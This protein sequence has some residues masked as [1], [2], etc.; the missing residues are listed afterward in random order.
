M[1]EAGQEPRPGGVIPR[2]TERGF[3]Q[4]DQ[5][6]VDLEEFG[7][8]HG[9]Q[10][11]VDD[12]VALPG[13]PGQLHGERVGYAGPPVRRHPNG[14]PAG[15]RQGRVNSLE[16]VLAQRTQ[17]QLAPQAERLAGRCDDGSHA[18]RQ[19][20]GEHAQRGPRRLTSTVDILDHHQAVGSRSQPTRGGVDVQ[21]LRIG[22]ESRDQAGRCTEVT[23]H[24]GPH[25]VPEGPSVAAARTT[26]K[27]RRAASWA[28]STASAV[29]P[30]P[31]GPTRT[32]RPPAP[33]VAW[34]SRWPSSAISRVRPARVTG[35]Q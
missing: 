18:H 23:E 33:A 28:A 2:S 35:P 1:R 16:L 22:Q 25:H 26:S 24:L 19:P 9:L 10:R 17:P 5:V 6:A 15:R 11:Q 27:P 20:A 7:G 29:F 13:E 34:S 31:V 4:P 32:S 8:R 12:R 30:E 14:V 21:R 3:E